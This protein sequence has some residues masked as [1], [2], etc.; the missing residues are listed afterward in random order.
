[1]QWKAAAPA[2]QRVRDDEL[3]ALDQTMQVRPPEDPYRN[4]LVDFQRW[5]MRKAILDA[6]V[7]GRNT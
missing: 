7:D 4:A 3:R 6:Y 5:M 2:L 1:M